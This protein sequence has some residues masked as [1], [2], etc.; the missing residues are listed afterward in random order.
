MVSQH[1]KLKDIFNLFF[2]QVQRIQI[3]LV[4]TKDM[5]KMETV[6]AVTT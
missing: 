5:E 1:G 6:I 2:C 3:R 4:T